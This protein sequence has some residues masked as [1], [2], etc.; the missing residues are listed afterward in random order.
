[1]I[2]QTSFPEE[3]RLAILTSKGDYLQWMHD[4][5]EKIRREDDARKA[6]TR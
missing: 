6:G 3:I 1:M 5:N 2:T 4:I